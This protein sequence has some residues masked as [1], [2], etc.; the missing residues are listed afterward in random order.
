MPFDRSKFKGVAS[1]VLKEQQK[2]VEK[3]NLFPSRTNF[4]KLT[5]G[6]NILRIYP[7]HR[8][9]A[10]YAYSKLVSWLPFQEEQEDK[11]K[12]TKSLVE[13]RKP[14]F[15]SRAHGPAPKDLVEEYIKFAF[16]LFGE[17]IQDEKEREK[18]LKPIT[19]WKEGIKP[20]MAWVLYAKKIKG[21][22]IKEFGRIE[23]TNG[24]MEKLNQIAARVD[25]NNNP[26]TIDV[27]SGADDG[28][29]V[30]IVWNKEEPD[31]RK[32]YEPT[33]LYE[34][35]WKLTDEEL[36]EFDELEPL[37]ALYTQCFTSSDFEKQI[38]GLQY[39]DDK[40]GFGI[41]Q[42]DDFLAIAEEI[43]EYLEANVFP[44]TD[45]KKGSEEEETPPN[46]LIDDVPT[47]PQH[48]EVIVR[49][50]NNGPAKPPRFTK[51]NPSTLSTPA[52]KP[53]AGGSRFT[54]KYKKK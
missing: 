29:A 15:N 32:K 25:S 21:E 31:N 36:A 3:L 26:I 11:K 43:T 17:E 39:F 40:F 42:H 38:S 24:L 22:G 20:Q 44:E 41:F 19:D 8:I 27:F 28:K 51:A 33:L 6:V 48:E 23:I 45:S 2:E 9:G 37:E 53:T 12:G 46:P 52:P 50:V 35:D 10:R 1:D 5:P 47:L 34:S 54:D 18:K 13:V 14:I 4:I 49:P 30:Q 16:K 7:A